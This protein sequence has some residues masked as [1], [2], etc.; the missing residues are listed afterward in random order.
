MSQEEEKKMSEAKDDINRAG[1]REKNKTSIKNCC[2]WLLTWKL[3]SNEFSACLDIS[4]R[5]FVVHFDACFYF[6][7]FI[8]SLSFVL[9]SY[10]AFI[11]QHTL[12]WHSTSSL[13]LFC[14]TDKFNWQCNDSIWLNGV[15]AINLVAHMIFEQFFFHFVF[16][17][18][19]WWMKNK[20][21]RLI[22]FFVGS[23][24][25]PHQ[26]AN[27]HNVACRCWDRV[28]AGL[29]KGEEGRNIL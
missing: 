7:L 21:I 4:S 20:I 12:L 29:I 6:F 1:V 18:F 2:V 8:C 14:S 24:N 28:Q 16:Y 11:S 25:L 15:D 27:V 3:E 9:T 22:C 23:G 19:V 26:L 10:L 17:F 13:S 5:L